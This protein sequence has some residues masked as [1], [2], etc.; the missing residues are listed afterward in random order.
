MEKFIKSNLTKISVIIPC[1]NAE[2]IIEETLI[3]LEKQTFNDFEVICVNDGSIDKT[4]E[5][6]NAYIKHSNLNIRCFNQENGGVSRARNKGI[7]EARSEFITFLD[8]DD[9]Y[10]PQ[11]LEVLYNA[12]KDGVDTAYCKLTRDLDNFNMQTP[13]ST[14]TINQNPNEFMRKGLYDMGKYGFCCYIYRKDIIKKNDIFFPIDIKYGEDREFLWKYLTH[15]KKGIWVNSLLYYYRDNPKS[16]V[17]MTNWRRTDALNSVKNTEQYLRRNNCR[18]SDEFAKYMYAR[19][20]LAVMFNFSKAKRKDLFIKLKETYDIKS[21]M[22]S[23]KKI[24]N[25]RYIRYAATVYL[26]NPFLFYL[27]VSRIKF[28]RVKN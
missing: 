22:K 7:N 12:M 24:T 21:T 4:M 14:A 5:K 8:S 1:Y 6:L 23:L 15:C 19:N 28:L 11:F 13:I 17:N 10:H 9:L 16:V 25:Q 3:S 26:L 18:F 27:I 20:M 2:E